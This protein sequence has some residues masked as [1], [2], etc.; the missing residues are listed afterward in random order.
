MGTGTRELEKVVE[1]LVS[2]DKHVAGLRFSRDGCAVVV[3]PR[4]G[5]V[6]QIFQLRLGPSV[7]KVM[8]DVVVEKKGKRLS[9]GVVAPAKR[10][11]RVPWNV[12]DLKRGR[13][14]AVVEV[15]EC[16]ADGRWMAF[17]TRKRTVH[18][19]PVNPY[20][21][22]PDQRSHLEGRV[23]NVDELVSSE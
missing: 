5:Q 14:S 4:D 3:V 17:A 18:V 8:G 10:E 2:K 11:T 9:V 7:G 6:A 1:I 23:R 21:G 16:A 22:K 20:G 12:Y 19:F 13:T 15:V